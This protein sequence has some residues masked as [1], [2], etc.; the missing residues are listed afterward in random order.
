MFYVFNDIPK[1][2]QVDD[3]EWQ[4]KVVSWTWNDIISKTCIYI[5]GHTESWHWLIADI[6][7][8]LMD[9]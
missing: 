4:Q 6:V 3:L 2:L 1:L 9:A 5:S 7:D 8:W